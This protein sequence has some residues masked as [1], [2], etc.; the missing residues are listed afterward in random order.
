MA[1]R[2]LSA[3]TERLIGLLERSRRA[4][5]APRSP[6]GTLA[7]ALERLEADVIRAEQE[8]TSARRSKAADRPRYVHGEW[9]HIFSERRGTTETRWVF[10]RTGWRLVAL[11]VR[12]G[13]AAP[14]QQG[15]AVEWADVEDSLTSA[16]AEAL[17]ACDE[18]GLAEGDIPPAWAGT[19]RPRTLPL[20]LDEA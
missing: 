10:D 4:E 16:N 6:H 12:E 13:A 7:E 18:H 11:Q 17:W 5:A 3:E 14:W 9:N 2:A 1:E 8:Q 20:L 15:L 19:L